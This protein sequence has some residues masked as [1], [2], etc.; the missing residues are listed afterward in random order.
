MDITLERDGQLLGPEI[1]DREASPDAEGLRRAIAAFALVA[2]AVEGS[3]DIDELL[4]VVARQ[5]SAL[6]GVDR[7][8]IHLRDE[9]AGVFR[10]CV[11]H[12]GQQEL[13]A[14]IKRSLAGVPADG[15]TAEQQQ[16]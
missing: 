3:S 10:G 13:G 8:S 12:V 14:D 5:I 16:T 7:C 15:M 6:V 9:S 11:G 2:A 4:E 1:A